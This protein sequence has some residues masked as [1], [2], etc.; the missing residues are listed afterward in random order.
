M[1]I[2]YVVNQCRRLF[3]LTAYGCVCSISSPGNTQTCTSAS[4]IKPKRAF[5]IGY[6]LALLFFA[7][8]GLNAQ[9]MPL[10]PSPGSKPK[11]RPANT[12]LA[13]P[14]TNTNGPASAKTAA[15]E[16]CDNGLDDDGDGFIDRFDSDCPCAAT[17][18]GS[19][20]STCTPS[21]SY[22]FVAQPLAVTQQ[23]SSAPISVCPTTRPWWLIW[24]MMVFLK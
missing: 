12:Q 18:Y 17:G 6:A 11:Q 14:V 15:S 22:T 20:V 16:I 8:Y 1:L 9:L 23:W 7:L 3:S 13:Q 10:G 2:L 19:Y 21:C 5:T 24:I 4:G